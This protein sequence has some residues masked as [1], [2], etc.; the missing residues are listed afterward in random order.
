M[1][2]GSARNAL[3]MPGLTLNSNHGTRAVVI[4]SDDDL[5]DYWI[6]ELRGEAV[7]AQ[8]RFYALGR[9]G[10]GEYFGELAASWR[11]WDG[12]KS[13]AA[14]EGDV[15]IAAS[16]DGRGTIGVVVELRGLPSIRSDPDWRA[17]LVL[18]LDAGALDGLARQAK[19]LG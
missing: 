3:P 11:G 19:A 5:G 10:L 14:L 6:A 13:W 8:R 4:R 1:K 16:H 15:V 18:T 9:T 7:W 2:T 12:D 17:A